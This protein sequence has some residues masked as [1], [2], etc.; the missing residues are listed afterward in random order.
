MQ[1]DRIVS[2]IIPFH[3]RHHLLD[4]AVESVCRQTY[5]QIELILVDDKSDSEYVL[6]KI[7]LENNSLFRL[8]Q[9]D[10]SMGPGASRETGRQA[11]TGNY[12]AYLDSD[13]L[14]H[15]EKL[16]KQVAMLESNPKAGMCYCTSGQFSSLPLTGAEP[17]RK[18]SAQ[19]FSDFL[20]TILDGRPW[21]TSACLWTREATDQIGSWF[22]GWAWEDYEYDFRAGCRGIQISFVPETLCYYRVDSGNTQLSRS[23]RSTQLKRKTKSLLKMYAEYQKPGSKIDQ[24][25]KEKFLRTLYF[26]AM[27][28]CYIDEKED[29]LVLLRLVQGSS[30]GRQKFLIDLALISGKFAS[31]RTLGDFLYRFRRHATFN[32]SVSNDE[33]ILA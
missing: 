22:E 19:Q 24:T 2:I 6:K 29:G 13:D 23:N 32:G 10:Q 25:T 31:S 30:S 15:P 33:S 26:Q 28:L 7:P 12:I 11:A 21:D 27:H 16:E 5:R 4:Q 14:W 18:R 17:V 8:L 20:P 1:N 3:N 9:H